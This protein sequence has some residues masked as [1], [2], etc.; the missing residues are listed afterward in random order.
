MTVY[1][2]KG[3]LKD[4]VAK[5]LQ[6]TFG[7]SKQIKTLIFGIAQKVCTLIMCPRGNA[8]EAITSN[9]SLKSLN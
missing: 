7:S 4:F 2:N 5:S 8:L 9:K 1:G 6:L 3:Q